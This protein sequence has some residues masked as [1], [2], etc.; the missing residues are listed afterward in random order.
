MI[1][2]GI[3]GGGSV[4]ISMLLT[5]MRKMNVQII[6]YIVTFIVG[7]ITSIILIGIHGLYGAFIGFTITSIIQIILFAI[8]YHY[9]YKSYL[10]QSKAEGLNQK[11]KE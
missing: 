10:Q 2:A 4:A 6:L 3:A 9:M 8:G 5:L 1:L 7:I 11:L